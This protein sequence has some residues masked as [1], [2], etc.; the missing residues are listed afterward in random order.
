VFHLARIIY[1]PD[2][3]FVS[4][5]KSEYSSL[6]SC[7]WEKKS[8]NQYCIE[9]NISTD[10]KLFEEINSHVV[11]INEKNE[12]LAKVSDYEIILNGTAIKFFKD[13]WK[14]WKISG[15]WRMMQKT[16]IILNENN[17]YKLN[18]GSIAT[19]VHSAPIDFFVYIYRKISRKKIEV[20]EESYK[21][22]FDETTFDPLLAFCILAVQIAK[23]S[24]RDHFL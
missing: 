5:K 7:L 9:S 14:S 19:V 10:L 12:I 18:N 1:F 20:L 4:S 21:V 15:E 11:A 2:R 17:E 16:L 24:R 23:K 22:E 3:G 6:F 8:R 13:N